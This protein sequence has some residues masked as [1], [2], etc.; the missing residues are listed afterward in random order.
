MKKRTY[1]IP[2]I[3]ACALLAFLQGC[4]RANSPIQKPRL[5]ITFLDV[6]QG[7]AELVRTPEGKTVLIDAGSQGCGS[8]TLLDK[9]GVTVI[10]DFILTHPHEDHYGNLRTLLGK[11]AVKRISFN[12]PDY[13][14][15]QYPDFAGLFQYITD[16]L[17]LDTLVL[18]SG[19]NLPGYNSTH[20]LCLWPA[21]NAPSEG[22]ADS[23]NAL[24]IVL[25]ISY[26]ASCAMFTGDINFDAE[27][28]LVN[29]GLL[30]PAAVLKTAHHGSK[31]ASSL[32]FLSALSPMMAIISV[33]VGNSYGH[34]EEE[35]LGRLQSAGCAV[36][37]TDLEGTIQ[38]WMEADGSVLSGNF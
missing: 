16:T 10:D 12:R 25:A 28:Q 29:N 33:G 27:A 34:P 35:T 13:P 21:P 20:L 3:C 30:V 6:G 7:D 36:M 11:F 15:S 32:A 9:L 22:I 8:D 2:T 19:R 23:I 37:R 14:K 26:G 1:V 4:A 18:S 38:L 5:S 24:S 17:R 31:N